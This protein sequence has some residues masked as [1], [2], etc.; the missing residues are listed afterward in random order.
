VTQYRPIRSVRT[1]QTQ[2]HAVQSKM[3][4][5][6]M[7]LDLSHG[8]QESAGTTAGN[9]LSN[10]T[11][12]PTATTFEVTSTKK[13]PDLVDELCSR[14]TATFT[15]A[16]CIAPIINTATIV[17]A[18]LINDAQMS[19]TVLETARPFVETQTGI[20]TTRT[21]NEVD[22]TIQF[23]P[24]AAE[25]FIGP[26]YKTELV[27]QPTYASK[28]TKVEPSQPTFDGRPAD[29]VNSS[30]SY[31]FAQQK[32]R[33]HQLLSRNLS[34]SKYTSEMM[35]GSKAEN[36]QRAKLSTPKMT[37]PNTF[38]PPKVRRPEPIPRNQTLHHTGS[39]S[40]PKISTRVAQN[41]HLSE[42]FSGEADASLSMK[43]VIIKFDMLQMRCCKCGK[44]HDSMQGLKKLA[45]EKEADSR[46]KRVKAEIRFCRSGSG[47]DACRLRRLGASAETKKDE[48]EDKV[49]AS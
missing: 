17:A 36:V 21:P 1:A 46:T 26:I 23:I 19:G 11:P 32:P 42:D 27:D 28:N 29:D 14:L 8:V 12:T 7:M 13:S 2:Y 34:S 48:I 22:A 33:V 43:K 18:Q 41:E 16:I 10:S 31:N 47:C 40:S 3:I 25:S 38:T 6:P 5:E 45:S 4:C 30:A 35:Q 9:P 37:R 44:K 15:N 49:V 39:L 20:G 24:E